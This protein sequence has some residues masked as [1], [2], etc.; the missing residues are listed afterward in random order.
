VLY[1]YVEALREV[2]NKSSGNPLIGVTLS[3]TAGVASWFVLPGLVGIVG[4]WLAA[5]CVGITFAVGFIAYPFF[6]LIVRAL[7]SWASV[8]VGARARLAAQLGCGGIPQTAQ[9]HS[10]HPAQ[11]FR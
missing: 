11:G 7:T 3:V 1:S 8:P 2:V 4:G 6:Y 10:R 9:G 5:A